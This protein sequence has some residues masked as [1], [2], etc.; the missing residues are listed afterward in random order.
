MDLK[1][2][3]TSF[4]FFSSLIFRKKNVQV[5]FIY[6]N[7]FNRRKGLNP[8]LEEMVSSCIHNK[9]DYL[10]IE[11]TDL[12]GA[13][14]Q[15]RDPRSIRLDFITFLIIV[16]KKVKL[17]DKVI[18]K[19]LHNVFFRNLDFSLC[20]NMAGY[21]GRLFSNLYKEKKI[22][23]YQHGLVYNGRNWW[24]EKEFVEEKNLEPLVFG[25]SFKKIILDK[26]AKTYSQ[27]KKIE[28]IGYNPVS[29]NFKFSPHSK[30][31]IFSLQL[32]IDYEKEER[33]RYLEEIQ[34][35]FSK[36]SRFFEEREYRF[37]LIHH[38]RVDKKII[39]KSNLVE[40]YKFIKEF[41]NISDV[42]E[43]DFLAHFTFNSSSVF[44]MSLQGIPTFFLD[45]LERRNP[46]IFYKIYEYPLNNFFIKKDLR[47]SV[48][49]SYMDNLSQD[50]SNEVKNWSKSF[51]NDYSEE[52]L[53]SLI[54]KNQQ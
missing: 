53:L 34:S 37:L 23:E 40:F 38:P 52:N 45:Y 4:S 27:S 41:T 50:L 25:D 6:L 8:F 39:K 11:D 16:L 33:I 28:I 2:L 35:F 44:E 10:L 48:L 46:E 5:I 1:S 3:I 49:I 14:K 17:S 47:E 54:K 32:T 42:H 12:K 21:S 9:I 13:Y 29:T 22:Y 24:N 31:I 51:F 20:I 7:H 26:A 18:Y 30:N 43:R 19:F 36:H 15:P